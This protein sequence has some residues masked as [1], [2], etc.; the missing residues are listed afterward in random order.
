MTSF[1]SSSFDAS[2]PTTKVVIEIRGKSKPPAPPP[3]SSTTR[4]SSDVI[5]TDH[6]LIARPASTRN[7]S[8]A[9]P[10]RRASAGDALDCLIYDKNS[11]DDVIKIQNDV[12]STPIRSGDPP[13]RP[14]K[15]F[16]LKKVKF[17]PEV[18]CKSTVHHNNNN[19]NP[20][21]VKPLDPNFL[22][23]LPPPV[24]PVTTTGSEKQGIS[25]YEPYL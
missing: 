24:K 8:T 13:I 20:Q 1:F 15:S 16:Q 25:Y 3:R 21:T 5:P 11:N 17:H 23:F 7:G 2:D 10:I 4:L 14:P 6:S 12:T 18:E 19:D 9:D 22:H